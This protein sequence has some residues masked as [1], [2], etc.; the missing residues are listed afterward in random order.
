MV[1]QRR[2]DDF[3]KRVGAAMTDFW[4]LVVFA[5]VLGA[6]IWVGGQLTVT[7][8]LMP[9]AHRLLPPSERAS[10]LRAVGRRFAVL[11]FALFVPLQLVTGVALAAHGSL[12]WSALLRPGD[13][14]ILLIKVLLFAAVMLASAFHGMAHARRRPSAARAASMAALVGSLVVVFL[15]VWL[16]ES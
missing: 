5:H 13:G 15:G 3:R 8:V 11:T 10:L 4:P 6:I 12:G 7:A 14:R 2:V 9:E 16:A 1:S